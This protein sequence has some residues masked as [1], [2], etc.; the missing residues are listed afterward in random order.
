MKN[1]AK[2]F[3]RYMRR[4]I[5]VWRM[6]RAMEAARESRIFVNKASRTDA[7]HCIRIFERVNAVE[8]DPSDSSHIQTISGMANYAA[9][10]RG[11]GR[12]F[13]KP[14]DQASSNQV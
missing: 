5:Y 2:K 4:K 10:H 12:I 8:F 1:I 7:L 14:I 9:L 13:K 6:L 3:I 11:L